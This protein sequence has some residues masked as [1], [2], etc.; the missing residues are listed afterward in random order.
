MG[1]P[2]HRAGWYTP[3]WL[4]RILLGIR[5]RSA[6]RIVPELQDLAVGDRILDSDAGNSYF[7]VAQLEPPHA[8]V[9]QSHTHPLPVYRDVNFSWA[10]V[11]EE[12][13]PGTRLLMRARITYTPLGPVRLTRLGI[14]TAFGIGDVIQAGGML[15]GIRRRA[16][17]QG[18]SGVRGRVSGSARC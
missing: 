17:R 4:D 8:L 15:A 18:G 9:L 14:S 13:F 1:F 12:A 3:F 2:T 7:T 5:V 6:D 16:G 10:F 11:L